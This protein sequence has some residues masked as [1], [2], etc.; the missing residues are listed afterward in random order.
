MV[1]NNVLC[2]CELTLLMLFHTY[3]EISENTLCLPIHLF[4]VDHIFYF[5]YLHF[6]KSFWRQVVTLTHKQ[7]EEVNIDI[8]PTLISYGRKLKSDNIW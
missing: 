8:G 4:L 7:L 3:T 2:S 6:T 1:R 5:Q